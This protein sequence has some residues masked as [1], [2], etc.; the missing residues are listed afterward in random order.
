MDRVCAWAA[1]QSEKRTEVLR[2]MTEPGSE[3]R[4]R[5]DVSSLMAKKKTKC[6]EKKPKKKPNRIYKSHESDRKLCSRP[7]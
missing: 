4:A 3:L 7:V 6:G 1:N 2:P 5:G